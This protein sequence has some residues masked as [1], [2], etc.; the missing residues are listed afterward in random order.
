MDQ[1]LSKNGETPAGSEETRGGV[2]I[3][4]HP[5]AHLCVIAQGN[6]EETNYPIYPGAHCFTSVCCMT[7]PPSCMHL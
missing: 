4:A 3:N 5:V 1:T 7:L 6:L 2:P